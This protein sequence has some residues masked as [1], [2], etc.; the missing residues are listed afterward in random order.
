MISRYHHLC[1]ITLMFLVLPPFIINMELILNMELEMCIPM[2]K[3]S[4]ISYC[5]DYL[6]WDID[7]YIFSFNIF[8]IIILSLLF[9][10][11]KDILFYSVQNRSSIVMLNCFLWSDTFIKNKVGWMTKPRLYNYTPLL[12]RMQG[13]WKKQWCIHF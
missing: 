1:H 9:Y 3:I 13:L 8:S 6:N 4:K 10:M 2:V 5:F 12:I 11:T 7:P